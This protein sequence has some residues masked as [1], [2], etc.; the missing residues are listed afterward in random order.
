MP[1]AGAL[2]RSPF[3][4]LGPEPLARAA[5]L[6]VMQDLDAG[7]LGRAL[8]AAGEGKMFGVLVGVDRRGRLGYLKAFSGTWFGAWEL[9]GFVPPVFDRAA[10]ASLEPAGAA[11]VAALEAREAAFAASSGFTAAHAAR[12]AHAQQT[13]AERAALQAELR[14]RKEARAEARQRLQAEGAAAA[15]FEELEGQSRG[16]KAR[17]RRFEAVQ[18]AATAALEARFAP[19]ARRLRAHGRLKRLVC[20]RLMRAL[21]DTYVLT[22]AHGMSLPLRAAFAP[23]APPAGAADC[24]APKLLAFA[25]AEGLRPLALAEFWWGASPR[26]ETRTHGVFYPACR[27]KCGPVLGFLLQGLPVAAAHSATPAV[28]PPLP[29]VFEDEW[30]CVVNKPAGL[31]SVP[32]RG[33]ENQDSV[34]RRL[35]AHARAGQ[36]LFL[37]HRLDQDTSGLLVAAKT[38]AAYVNLQKQFRDRLVKKDYVALAEGRLQGAG[39]IDL[40][41]R[42]DVDDRPRQLHDPERGKPAST[43]WKVLGHEGPHTRLAMQPLT[44]RTH[45]LR[46]HAA[47]PLGLAAP[48]VGD[49]LYGRGGGRLMLHAAGLAFTHPASGLPLH[50]TTE[51]P[52]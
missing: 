1:A 34:L 17:R 14:A 29:I 26:S 16:D 38:K 43:R 8:A 13:H 32:G 40:P 28:P 46:V 7:A 52:F 51:V 11:V 31:L 4:P 45:Q 9:P 39:C 27:G 19:L 48:L 3:D 21:H 10:R 41:L 18:A 44:G 42:L 20:R 30:L 15:A 6:E 12:E 47:H 25:L 35:E 33:A 24:A 22:N 50:V 23:A 36:P 5:A 2:L 49:R 37:V